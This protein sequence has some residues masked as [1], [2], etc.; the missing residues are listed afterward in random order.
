M[1]RRRLCAHADLDGQG[2][3]WLRTGE[4]CSLGSPIGP[5][6]TEREARSLP[7]VSTVRDL[8]PVSPQAHRNHR[9]LC[10][11]SAAAGIELG[12]YDHRVLTWL[13]GWEPQTC[14]AIAGL[15][16]RAAAGAR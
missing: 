13:A 2:M 6:E 8:E 12:A 7:A 15:I 10:E 14:A 11:E 1:I 9:L 5:Y 16:A 3:H 4:S